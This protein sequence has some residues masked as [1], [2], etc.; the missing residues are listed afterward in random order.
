MNGKIRDGIMLRMALF[1]NTNRKMVAKLPVQNAIGNPSA[2]SRPSEPNSRTVSQAMS[3]SRPIVQ[4][5]ERDA[6]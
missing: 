6:G 1:P 5:G 2:S 4:A 3:I